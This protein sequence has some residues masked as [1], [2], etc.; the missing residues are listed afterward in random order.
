MIS[1]NEADD[2]I[3]NNIKSFSTEQKPL[4]ESY[5][6]VLQEDVFADRDQPPFNR[7]AMDGIAVNLSSWKK[8][9]VNNFTLAGSQQAGEAPLTLANDS[10]CLEVM[11]GAVLPAESNCVI[12]VENIS[13]KD[14]QVTIKEGMRYKLMQNVHPQG[15][16]VKLG[17]L[18]LEKGALIRSP[19][20]AV[21]ASVGKASIQVSQEPKI[22]VFATGDELVAVDQNPLP[23]QI[24]LSNS[25]SVRCALVD[26]GYRDVDLFHLKDI[27][28]EI[29]Q[30]LETTLDEYDVIV[31]SGGVSMGRFDLVPKVLKDLGVEVLFHKV[32]MK[33]GKPFW[34]G[35]TKQGKPVF[36]LPG[37]PV[38][39]LIG[40]Y[41][42]VL[43][44]LE[45][46][47]GVKKIKREHVVLKDDFNSKTAF[48]NF[49]PVNCEDN[50]NGK[51][52][53]VPNRP[54]GSGDFTSLTK[55]DGF[56]QLEANVKEFS[57]GYI[58]PF[59]KW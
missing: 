1:V 4:S 3:F 41:R 54:N 5:G 59:I 35:K 22:A 10:L 31:L 39:T 49:V 58:T 42:F 44:Y 47:R 48:T 23:H 16:D 55:T 12:P 8:D 27:E 29:K 37:N 34:F 26:H 2:I 21:L 33:P 7:V 11:T 32:E 43:P 56:I 17:T 57:S 36:A 9:S 24:R 52:L 38:S 19:E 50:A 53:A 28:E 40:C 20:I 15:A 6:C 13:V 51:R 30:S 18:L 25:H 45:R 14:D 46:A